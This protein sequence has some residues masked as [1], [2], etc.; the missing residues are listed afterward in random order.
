MTEPVVRLPEVALTGSMSVEEAIAK[1]ESRRSFS[2]N[3][4]TLAQVA[5]L[6]YAAY[7]LKRGPA[8]R[9]SGLRTAPSAGA[10]YPLEVLLASGEGTVKGLASGLHVYLADEHALRPLVSED[11]RSELARAA[12]GQ[13]FIAVAPMTLAI[14]SDFQ[15]T[16]SRYG[17]R[18]ERYVY[19][20]TGHLG[21][22]VY[23]QAE[24]LGL[25]TVA[26][27]AFRDEDVARVLRLPRNLKPVYLMPVGYVA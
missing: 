20:D 13:S 3:P 18:G 25:G 24:A 5:Q 15:R 7:G 9:R 2:T 8:G 26:I 27:G 17:S 22:N 4:L 11:I 21:E 1:R 19:I 16:T 6:L 10:R 14:V 23:L 12:L